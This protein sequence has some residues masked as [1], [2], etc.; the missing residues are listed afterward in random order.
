M[1]LCQNLLT[2]CLITSFQNKKYQS[3]TLSPNFII[4]KTFVV[5]EVNHITVLWL[6]C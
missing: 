1:H 3:I 6:N 4:I 2:P 5:M